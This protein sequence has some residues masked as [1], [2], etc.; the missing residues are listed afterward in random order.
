MATINQA[1]QFQELLENHPVLTGTVDAHNADGTSSITM[2]GGG[3][4]RAYGQTVPVAGIALVQNN[5]VIA[6]AASLPAFNL[7]V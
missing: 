1:R 2:T 5:T 4:V 6:A 3:I 7:E